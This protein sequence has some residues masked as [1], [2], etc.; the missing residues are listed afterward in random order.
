M[1]RDRRSCH[2]AGFVP[3]A[4]D[5]HLLSSGTEEGSELSLLDADISQEKVYELGKETVGKEKKVRVMA[6]S[7]KRNLI[8]LILLILKSN[9]DKRHNF[10]GKICQDFLTYFETCSFVFLKELRGQISR[11]L[12][13]N[14]VAINKH[15][16]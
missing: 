9:T 1:S 10:D 2:P 11:L 12:Q 16:K 8:W 7:L 4:R 13:F 3:S 15:G 5:E 6:I 14:Y